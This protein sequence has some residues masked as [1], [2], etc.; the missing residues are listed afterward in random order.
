MIYLMDFTRSLHQDE[1]KDFSLGLWSLLELID[2]FRM[3]EASNPCDKVYALLGMSV[4]GNETAALLPD[5]DKEWPVVFQSLAKEVFGHECEA[6]WVESEDL[7]CGFVSTTGIVLGR[8]HEVIEY[9]NGL[10]ER[11]PCALDKCIF[12]M[13]LAHC[14]KAGVVMCCGICA[15]W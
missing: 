8:I 6:I 2:S 1:S 15:C 10:Q 4:P 7:E 12:G 14:A 3:Y 13:L 9:Y 11:N 5:Y